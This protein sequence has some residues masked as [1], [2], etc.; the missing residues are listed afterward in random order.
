M[1]LNIPVVDK[2]LRD[3]KAVQ[4]LSRLNRTYPGKEDTYVLDFV[5]P[6]ERI[7]AAFQKFYRETS[8]DEEVNFDLIYTTQ[9]I[10][11]GISCLRTSGMF[12]MRSMGRKTSMARMR[13]TVSVTISVLSAPL[14][15]TKRTGR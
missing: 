9:N 13:F 6:V 15:I 12:W 10:L 8:L 5:N 11:H 2:E 4:T 3:V 14:L 7:K 1:N